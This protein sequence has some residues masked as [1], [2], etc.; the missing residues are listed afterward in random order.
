VLVLIEAESFFN[1]GTAAVAFGI[2]VALASGQHLTP[3]GISA[4]LAKTI[5]GGIF[6]HGQSA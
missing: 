5:L 6:K 2:V 1:D 4:M 3:L